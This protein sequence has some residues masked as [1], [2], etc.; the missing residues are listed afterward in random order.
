MKGFLMGE[1]VSRSE[2]SWA[3]VAHRED[4]GLE[5]FLVGVDRSEGSWAGS[6]HNEDSECGLLGEFR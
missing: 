6:A 4:V 2:G 1:G 5:L 3:G